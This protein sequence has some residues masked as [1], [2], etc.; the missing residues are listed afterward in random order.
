M[1]EDILIHLTERPTPCEHDFQGWREFDDGCG[2]EAVCCK[3]GIGAFEHTM[4]LLP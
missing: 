3:C 2:G 1:A 4:R